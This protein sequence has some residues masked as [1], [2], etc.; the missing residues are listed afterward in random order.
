MRNFCR[1]STRFGELCS[2][3]KGSQTPAQYSWKTIAAIYGKNNKRLSLG[4]NALMCAYPASSATIWLF[5]NRCLSFSSCFPMT[6]RVPPILS[7]AVGLT[8]LSAR[9]AA[10]SP[11]RS[12]LSAGPALWSAVDVVANPASSSARSWSAVIRRSVS[13]SGP[14]TS[15]P[16]RRRGC[17]RCSFSGNLG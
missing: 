1:V 4:K 2:N 6:R 16:A 13:G 11:N 14:R 7:A 5:P 12:A 8:A 17:R 10:R 9:I 15:S 3:K